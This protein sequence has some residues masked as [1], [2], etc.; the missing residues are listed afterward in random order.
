[1]SE[2][3]KI[4]VKILAT[5]NNMRKAERHHAREVY[6]TRRLTVAQPRGNVRSN[7]N[8]IADAITHTTAEEDT[9]R[10]DK[11]NIVLGIVVIAIRIHR[12]VRSSHCSLRIAQFR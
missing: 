5:K 10:R 8:L 4:R 7:S 6:P 3:D 1:M 11:L 2:C 12:T 9:K